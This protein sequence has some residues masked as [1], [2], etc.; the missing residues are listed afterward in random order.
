MT[1]QESPAEDECHYAVS[2]HM[3]LCDVS[4]CA[5]GHWVCCFTSVRVTPHSV[6]QN[7]SH[8]IKANYVRGSSLAAGTT[9]E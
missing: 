9:S 7:V 4:L 3:P 8:F 2:K 5:R 6:M 1:S